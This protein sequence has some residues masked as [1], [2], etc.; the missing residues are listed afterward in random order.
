VIDSLTREA[1]GFYSEPIPGG[2]PDS[3]PT[4]YLR[5]TADKAFAPE[6]QD[7]LIAR[8][9]KLRVE[10][11]DAGHLPMLGHPDQIAAKLNAVV[12]RARDAG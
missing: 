7:R 10:Q 1:P 12:E 9:H 8:L 3:M 2:I 5:L 11:I 6:V 4:M